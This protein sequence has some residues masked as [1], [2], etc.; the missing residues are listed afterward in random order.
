M[1]CIN[2]LLSMMTAGSGRSLQSATSSSVSSARPTG[3][4]VAEGP[5]HVG[6]GKRGGVEASPC[7]NPKLGAAG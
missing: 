2:P 6:S 3:G 7:A 1:M 4:L 5:S